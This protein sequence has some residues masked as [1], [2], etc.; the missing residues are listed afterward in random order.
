MGGP[1]FCTLSKPTGRETD[2]GSSV[3]FCSAVNEDC[4]S[5]TGSSAAI[6]L[7]TAGADR[8]G[9]LLGSEWKPSPPA[10]PLQ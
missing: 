5:V 7:V 3:T 4:I 10:M 8:Y 9:H 6:P 1:R 2:S